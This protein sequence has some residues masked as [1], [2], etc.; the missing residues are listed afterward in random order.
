[1]IEIA[2]SV[3]DPKDPAPRHN[4][5]NGTSAQML[6]SLSDV[7]VCGRRFLEAGMAEKRQAK[8]MKHQ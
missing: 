5:A 7:G 6:M 4:E 3:Q 2:S 1:M 8:K